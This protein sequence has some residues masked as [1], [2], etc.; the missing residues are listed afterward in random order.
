MLCK[1]DDVDD[2]DVDFDMEQ[3][4]KN[5]FSK[6]PLYMKNKNVS[7][8]MGKKS[9]QIPYG[10]I[11]IFNYRLNLFDLRK[12][13]WCKLHKIASISLKFVQPKHL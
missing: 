5:K 1:D 13:S 8:V 9:D 4:E 11:E 10:K 3:T 7:E 2:D 6:F 12:W